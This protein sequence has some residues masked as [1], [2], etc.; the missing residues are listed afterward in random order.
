MER[1][2][3]EIRDALSTKLDLLE[4]GL[5]LIKIEKYLANPQGT[6]GFIDLFATDQQGKYVLIELK[7]SDATSREALHEVLKYLEAVKVG[8]SARDAEARIFIVSTEWNELLVPFSSFVKRTHCEVKGFALEVDSNNVPTKAELVIPLVLAEDRLFAPW[9]ELNL[10]ETEESLKTGLESY[11]TSCSAKGIEN[12]VLVV[13]VP[14]PGHHKRSMEA[15]REYLN[16][17]RLS[18]GSPA[19]TKTPEEV[20]TAIP[21]YKFLVYFATLQLSEELCCDAIRKGASSD[22]LEEFESCVSEMQ[23]DERL[24]YLHTT[25]YSVLPKAKRDFYEI[26]YP[27]KFGKKLLDDE[28]WN[29]KEV[30]RYGSLK[31]NSVL[32]DDSI[33]QDLRGVDGNNLRTYQRRFSPSSKAELDEVRLGARRCLRDNP[34][35][36]NQILRVLDEFLPSEPNV[37]A[38]LSIFN[39]ANLCFALYLSLASE[40]GKQYIPGYTLVFEKDGLPFTAI[41]GSMQPT[42]NAPSF[43]GLL[44]KYYEGDGLNFVMSLNW[45]GYEQRDVQI[46][47]DLGM[48]YKTFKMEDIQG[49][50]QRLYELTEMGWETCGPVTRVSGFQEFVEDYPDFILDVC[51]YYS[52][53]WDGVMVTYSRNEVAVFRT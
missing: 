22:E 18:V 16:H 53:H 39:P 20:A 43:T 44:D 35:W 8:F 14:P 15:T 52:S 13:M 29:I 2:E 38:T 51:D 24:C 32:T 50:L 31:A 49:S 21:E 6:R 36:R 33:V 26:G 28:G 48:T 3:A 19:G 30:R 17:L 41:F 23:G 40:D 45:G 25:A 12:F 47:R 4:P 27:A 37:V 10:Y 34:L 1:R 9:H 7:R 5:Q 11:E 46:S 42:G